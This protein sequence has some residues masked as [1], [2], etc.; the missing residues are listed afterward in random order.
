[1][2]DGR[3]GAGGRRHVDRLP[4]GVAA[5][6]GTPL[7]N[8]SARPLLLGIATNG[9]H[10]QRRARRRDSAALARLDSSAETPGHG[11]RA[12]QRI[13]AA[14]AV[15]AVAKRV[16][17]LP[18][19]E[20]HVLALI[21]W[22]GADVRRGRN[23]ARHPDRHC[24]LAPIACPSTLLRRMRTAQRPHL[25]GTRSRVPKEP[26]HGPVR[27]SSRCCPTDDQLVGRRYAL[28]AELDTRT[29]GRGRYP[30]IRRRDTTSATAQRCH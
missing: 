11:D 12:I 26:I 14:D 23:G 10:G 8:A 28:V 2:A 5:T 3:A 1:M 24:A 15:R 29:S 7:A 17:R 19:K 22:G 20:L 25:A 21:A 18:S 27:N 6:S 16:A 13:A 4:G 30:V 9:V